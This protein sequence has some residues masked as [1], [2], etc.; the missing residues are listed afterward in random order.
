MDGRFEMPE[1]SRHDD[2]PPAPSAAEFPARPIYRALLVRGL[3]PSEA[4]NLTAWLAGLPC[5]GLHWTIPEVDAV[6]RRRAELQRKANPSLDDLPLAEPL[7]WQT[8]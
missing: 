3:Q 1:P 8:S 5:A 7:T 2:P 6:L 4:A